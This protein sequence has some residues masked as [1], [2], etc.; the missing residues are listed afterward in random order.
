VKEIE[1]KEKS[2]TRAP[3]TKPKTYLKPNEKSASAESVELSAEGGIMR[4]HR[5]PDLFFDGGNLVSRRRFSLL[6]Q[7]SLKV[8]KK[9]DKDLILSL[10]RPVQAL[11]S[12]E[13]VL[14]RI[15][16][17]DDLFNSLVSLVLL[18]F[19]DVVHR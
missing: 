5:F 9:N 15:L 12:L 10:L 14:T 17:A 16:V 18:S 3:Y 6:A 8:R 19:F 1:N 11:P 2:R 4:L 7:H 13:R